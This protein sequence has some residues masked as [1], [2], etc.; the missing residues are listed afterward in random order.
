MSI[1]SEFDQAFLKFIKTS[2][3]DHFTTAEWAAKWMGDR[4]ALEAMRETE[5]EYMYMISA[6]DIRTL[7]KELGG[8]GG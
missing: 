5:F 3:S 1:K 2:D 6:E 8:G 4:I 7:V